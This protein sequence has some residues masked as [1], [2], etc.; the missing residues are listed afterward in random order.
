MTKIPMGIDDTGK[1]KDNASK[2]TREWELQW[3]DYGDLP[4]FIPEFNV[5][6]AEF[7]DRL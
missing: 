6:L 4:S 1:D 7:I 2:D 3:N 5:A